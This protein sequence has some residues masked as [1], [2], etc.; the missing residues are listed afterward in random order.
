M[1]ITLNYSD[2]AE[3]QMPFGLHHRLKLPASNNRV[4]L[5]LPSGDPAGNRGS[6]VPWTHR[7]MRVNA[8]DERQYVFGV[9]R[10]YNFTTKIDITAQINVVSQYYVEFYANYVSNGDLV[11][12]TLYSDYK[13]IRADTTLATSGAGL[14]K[15]YNQWIEQLFRFTS[16]LD[17]IDF[18][19]YA[20]PFTHALD[21]DSSGFDTTQY[22]A[23]PRL[24]FSH[25]GWSHE[26]S[27]FS[28]NASS[29]GPLSSSPRTVL[30][31]SLNSPHSVGTFVGD[32]AYASVRGGNE[33]FSVIPMPV[34]ITNL[35][36]FC[37][38]KPGT[39]DPDVAEAIKLSFSI[40]GQT[41]AIGSSP[42]YQDS[43]DLYPIYNAFG[44]DNDLYLSFSGTGDYSGLGPAYREA[45]SMDDGAGGST[46]YNIVRKP[47][48]LVRVNDSI[49]VSA[50]TVGLTELA[51]E[52]TEW[53]IQFG[54][55]IPKAWEAP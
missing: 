17:R 15:L 21:R 5:R 42:Q 38:F 36:F 27:R 47:L 48:G 29:C 19:N 22:T 9:S 55:L 26:G 45:E 39:Y 43:D 14:D 10:A 23:H 41:K 12:I 24:F 40:D 20:P 54:G 18:G 32:P 4:W 49:K 11:E 37:K 34:Y 52:M 7:F 16:N 1:S 13:D 46:N 30:E 35:V 2:K 25:A 8:W 51:E 33:N 28:G 53:Y 44:P 6:L 31:W 3:G 50:S